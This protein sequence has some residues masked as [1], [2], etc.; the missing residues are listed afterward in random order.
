MQTYNLSEEGFGYNYGRLKSSA[1]YA[2]HENTLLRCG[3]IEKC[4]RNLQRHF[5][6]GRPDGRSLFRWT[7]LCWACP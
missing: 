4:G 5:V 1:S 3:K 6:D 2:S 7:A